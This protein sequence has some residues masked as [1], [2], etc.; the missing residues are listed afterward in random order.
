MTWLCFFFGGKHQ[1]GSL[2]QQK[3]LFYKGCCYL[4]VCV[5][6]KENGMCSHLKIVRNTPIGI[7]IVISWETYKNAVALLVL[8]SAFSCPFY[9]NKA[10]KHCNEW[11]FYE[12]HKKIC[13]G[14][15]ITLGDNSQKKK[16]LIHHQRQKWILPTECTILLKDILNM[17]TSIYFC[18]ALLTLGWSYCK[19]GEKGEEQA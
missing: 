18:T 19:F 10:W 11:V 5:C 16:H 12:I 6:V 4:F 1:I 14:F 9:S 17:L 3:P 15:N 8:T 7:H 2:S 13:S